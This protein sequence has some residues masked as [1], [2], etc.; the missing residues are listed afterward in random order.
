[1]HNDMYYLLI[2][3]SMV[4]KLLAQAL[5]RGFLMNYEINRT[6]SLTIKYTMV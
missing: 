5:P 2:C 3:N 4:L 6:N 1:M